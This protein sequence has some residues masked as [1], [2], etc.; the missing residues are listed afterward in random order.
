[1]DSKL[2]MEAI[3]RQIGKREQNRQDL[4]G[5]VLRKKT[6]LT[7]GRPRPGYWGATI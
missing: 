6:I 2:S 5:S 7:W 4:T 3:D 1:M